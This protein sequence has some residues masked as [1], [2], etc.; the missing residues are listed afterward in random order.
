[1]CVLGCDYGGT[2][3]TTRREAERIGQ[4]LQLRPGMR[5][6]D[7]GAGAGWPGLFLAQQHGCEAILTDL[8][9][10]GLRIAL[11]R[12]TC[13]SLRERCSAVAADGASLPF[14]AAS[15]DAVTHSDVLCCMPEKLSL[16]QECRRV[17][18]PC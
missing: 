14:V 1:R 2:S 18:T 6:L 9:L 3:W 5:L 11:E 7:V 12:A 4:M 13:D 17:A 10:S 15:F 16:L 8:P